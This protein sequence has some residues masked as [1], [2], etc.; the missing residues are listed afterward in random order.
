MSTKQC[1]ETTPF[2]HP[3]FHYIYVVFAYQIFSAHKID[4]GGQACNGSSCHCVLEQ[5]KRII[6]CSNEVFCLLTF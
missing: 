5:F 6:P 3:I 4:R 1:F 2:P